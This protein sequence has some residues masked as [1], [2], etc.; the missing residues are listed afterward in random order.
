MGCGRAGGKVIDKVLSSL[1]VRE[2]YQRIQPW[3]SAFDR[4]SR[5]PN[6]MALLSN[7]QLAAASAEYRCC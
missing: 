3:H 5:M 2:L 6:N 7:N 4:P 1:F